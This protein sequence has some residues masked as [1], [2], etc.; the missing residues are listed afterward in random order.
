MILVTDKQTYVYMYVLT[1]CYSKLY[2]WFIYVWYPYV[3]WLVVFSTMH[4]RIDYDFLKVSRL[5]F[6]KSFTSLKGLMTFGKTCTYFA[7]TN[8]K[9]HAFVNHINWM[10]GEIYF[11]LQP[12]QVMCMVSIYL[13]NRGGKSKIFILVADVDDSNPRLR[14]AKLSYH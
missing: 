8:S 9:L 12:H 3:I 7:Y 4:I 2:T 13:G 11:T 14:R 10:F 6:D 5:R 1:I